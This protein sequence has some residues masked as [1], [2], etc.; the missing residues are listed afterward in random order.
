MLA[1][2]RDEASDHAAAAEVES[3]DASDESCDVLP[4]KKRKGVASAPKH[5]SQKNTSISSP[6][7]NV[8]QSRREVKDPF[9]SPLS[10]N[11]TPVASSRSH[12]KNAPPSNGTPSS[13]SSAI[14]SAFKKATMNGNT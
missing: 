3:S 5:G 10:A 4:A 6:A 12:S 9:A 11:K 1:F 13:R 14:E 8:K 2:H 7:L